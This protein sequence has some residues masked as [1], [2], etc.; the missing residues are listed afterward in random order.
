MAKKNKHL[1]KYDKK[2]IKENFSFMSSLVKNPV[3]ICE[4]CVRTASVAEVLCRPIK[5]A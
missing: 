4:R 5:M 1:C 3:F 2:E